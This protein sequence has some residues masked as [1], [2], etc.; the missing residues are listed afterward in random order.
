MDDR[1][2]EDAKANWMVCAVKR[3]AAASKTVAAWACR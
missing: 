2:H 3:R 1:S